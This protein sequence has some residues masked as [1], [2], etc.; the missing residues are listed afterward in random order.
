LS[1]KTGI[2]KRK[3]RLTIQPRLFNISCLKNEKA[4]QD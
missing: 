2:L 1:S 4:H 3:P